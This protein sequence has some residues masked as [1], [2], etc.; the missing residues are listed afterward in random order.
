MPAQSSDGVI[1]Y[2][3]ENIDLVV[4]VPKTPGGKPSTIVDVTVTPPKVLREGSI[5][6]NQG[7]INIVN[8]S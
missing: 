2:F 5:L 8:I 3:G 1:N 4:D 7:R 6:L